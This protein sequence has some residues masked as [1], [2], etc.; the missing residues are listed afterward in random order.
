M[1]EFY[2]GRD[3]MTIASPPHLLCVNEERGSVSRRQQGNSGGTQSSAGGGGSSAVL[4]QFRNAGH[5]PM[6]Q[7]RPQAYSASGSQKSTTTPGGGTASGHGTSSGHTTGK[8][9]LSFV[10][11]D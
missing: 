7:G 10:K 1:G 4:N 6:A 3:L 11:D 9:D 2:N 8:A 5:T